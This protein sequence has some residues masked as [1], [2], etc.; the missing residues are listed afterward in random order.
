MVLVVE[1]RIMVRAVKASSEDDSWEAGDLHGA[2]AIGR[3]MAPLA[4][5]RW[6]PGCHSGA[7]GPANGSPI[8]V[9]LRRCLRMLEGEGFAG[10]CRRTWVVDDPV[11]FQVDDPVPFQVDDTLWQALS[12]PTILG[13]ALWVLATQQ[14]LQA[15]PWAVLLWVLA[16]L[17]QV[18]P[19]PTHRKGMP[20]VMTEQCIKRKEVY[21]FG[22]FFTPRNIKC[23]CNKSTETTSCN[24]RT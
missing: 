11:P 6:A 21:N 17:E 5:L 20:S 3:V 12:G 15:G 24:R 13:M 4:V 9:E 1:C 19:R 2:V 23:N 16:T 10:V 18:R 22:Y 8:P 7:A 14:Q